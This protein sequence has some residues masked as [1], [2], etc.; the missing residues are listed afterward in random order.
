[1]QV[2]K[3]LPQQSNTIFQLPWSTD[4]II[5]PPGHKLS[6]Q[7]PSQRE[8]RHRPLAPP[9]SGHIIKAPPVCVHCG[10]TVTHIQKVLTHFASL[11]IETSK[12]TIAVFLRPNQESDPLS[13][14]STRQ[15]T[16]ETAPSLKSLECA[17]DYPWPKSKCG[18]YPSLSE[19]A[20]DY[21]LPK[22]KSDSTPNQIVC[23]RYPGYFK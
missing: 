6:P 11:L 15:V 14:S 1:M 16:V 7:T 22:N 23:R 21:P 10:Q 18:H 5:H 3:K 9:A 19:C 8:H 20:E 13:Q 4:T 12:Q 17:D 2:A